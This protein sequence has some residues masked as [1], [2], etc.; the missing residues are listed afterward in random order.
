M[1]DSVLT[2]QK[3]R[4]GM[5][6]ELRELCQELSERKDEARKT[7]QNENMGTESAF[8]HRTDEGEYLY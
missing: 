6:Q 5:T 2:R 3:I 8:L 4:D 1:V 7:L